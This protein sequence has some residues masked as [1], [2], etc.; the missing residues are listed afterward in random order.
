MDLLNIFE[1]G[2]PHLKKPI[3]INHL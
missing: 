1:N 2:K 3:M